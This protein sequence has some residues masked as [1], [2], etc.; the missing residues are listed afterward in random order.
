MIQTDRV[1][2]GRNWM[3]LAELYGRTISPDALKAMLDAVDDLPMA[4]VQGV[5]NSWMRRPES[6]RFPLPVDIR[7]L[8][9]PNLSDEEMAR[10]SAS[11]VIAAVSKFGW[12]N[13]SA[14]R[15][16]IG[17]LGWLA[18]GRAGGWLYICENLG[19]TLSLTTFQAQIRDLCATN[20]KLAKA[21]QLD[22]PVGIPGSGSTLDALSA[23]PQKTIVE[24][25]SK[26]S[27]DQKLIKEIE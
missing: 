1:F 18:I 26:L 20:V 6:H 27:N 19:R 13:S 12:N 22:Q 17:E 4:A 7:N 21:G 9:K 23:G 24:I 11:R 16:W 25:Q 10:E 8:I 14:A 2:I 5:L 15:E 3:A